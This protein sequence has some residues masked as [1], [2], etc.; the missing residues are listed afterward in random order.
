MNDNTLGPNVTSL[1][2]FRDARKQDECQC[3][4]EELVMVCSTC[5]SRSWRL[6]STGNIECCNCDVVI[7]VD[8][9]DPADMG[10]RRVFRTVPTDPEVI[11]K[12]EDDAGTV[13]IYNSGSEELARARVIK[14]ATE[15][16]TKDDL[17][18][19]AAYNKEG[20]GRWWLNVVT[21]DDQK[22]VVEKIKEILHHAEAP[23]K[24]LE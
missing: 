6:M 16:A 20:W 19:V 10:W 7:P 24:N 2:N 9:E 13:E 23:N 17:M 12:L 8:V 11:A 3:E 4:P 14:T 21:K 18:L 5:E 1:G 15:W 22:F